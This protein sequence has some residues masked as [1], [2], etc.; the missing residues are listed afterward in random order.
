MEQLEKFE[1]DHGCVVVMETNTGKIKAIAN[2]GRTDVGT[3]YEKLNYAVG[4]AH[5]PGSTFKLVSMIAA[6]EDKVIN[7]D[8]TFKPFNRGKDCKTEET[9]YVFKNNNSSIEDLEKI[10][11][12]KR[13][14]IEINNLKQIGEENYSKTV[15]NEENKLEFPDVNTYLHDNVD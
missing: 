11:A 10:P 14:G 6:L 1:A 3:Y 4:E 15:L 8:I 7:E 2:L 13:M 12:Y 5:E 9:L